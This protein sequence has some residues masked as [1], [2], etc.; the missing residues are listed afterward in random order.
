MFYSKMSSKKY[1]IR[2]LKGE[3]IVASIKKFCEELNIKNAEISAIGSVES[4]T[5]AHYRVDTKKYKEKTLKGIFELTSLIGSVAISE[6]E[7]LVHVHVTISDD[8]MRAFGGHLVKGVV[9]A[10]VEVFL[11]SFESKYTKSH[12]KEIGLKLWNL[13]DKLQKP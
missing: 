2:L 7:P 3:E 12:D 5:L 4:P 6:G 10:T 9:S 8:E 11:E 13:D 1:L